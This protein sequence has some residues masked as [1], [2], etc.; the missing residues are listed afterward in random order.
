[1]DALQW[2][3]DRL[4]VPGNPLVASLLFVD[5][6]E[7]ERILALRGLISELAALDDPGADE[8]VREARFGWWYEALR[9][10]AEHPALRALIDSGVAERVEPSQCLELLG[11]I[12]VA[13]ANPRFERSEQLWAHCLAI[14]GEAARLE[15]Q[16][17]G[18]AE[19][20]KI[21]A[22]TL[23]AAGYLIRLVRDLAQDAAN[24]RWLVPLD[25]Q[26]QFQVARSDVLGAPGGGPGWD[27]LVRTLLERALR[28]GDA[29]AA[30]LPCRY[31]HLQIYWSLDR[32]LAGQL[33][34][35]PREILR[36]RILPGHVGNVWTAWR[37]ARRL[38]Q[39]L[40]D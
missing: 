23:G 4:M 38:N 26:A 31:R 8:T 39:K 6:T 9:K 22:A 10:G 17:S 33:A 35:H 14:G 28:E 40:T 20:D 2:C 36:R 21:K 30:G 37:A 13:S 16:L 32:R 3:R 19:L 29:A 1:M 18:A 27:G 5:S 34:R 15:L 12:R 7:R 11:A 25:L 24:N